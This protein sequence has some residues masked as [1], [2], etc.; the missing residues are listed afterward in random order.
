MYAV[1]EING[2]QYRAEQ[3][4]ALKV[5]RIDEEAGESVSFD[6]VLLLSGETGVKVG[7]PYVDGA[8][9]KAVIEAEIKADKVIVFKYKPK[10]DYRRTRG[11]RQRYTVLKVQEI[12]GA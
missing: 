5:D 1:V 8:S 11:H 7:N 3:G 4:K 12:V 6:K 9:V 10:K 2:K